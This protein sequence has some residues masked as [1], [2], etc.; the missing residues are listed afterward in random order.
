MVNAKKHKA[1]RQLTQEELL[2]DL[3]INLIDVLNSNPDGVIK[4]LTVN[5]NELNRIYNKMLA[6]EGSVLAS[7]ECRKIINYIFRTDYSLE[8]IKLNYN[9]I[10]L[11]ADVI[12]TVLN[13]CYE[14]LDIFQKIQEL[15]QANIHDSKY[16]SL[17]SV[18]AM[19][20]LNNPDKPLEYYSS[21]EY[22]N[23]INLNVTYKKD[24]IH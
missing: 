16:L 1:K 13:L 11:E 5:N 24:K 4:E 3:D 15:Q 10:K 2:Q 23:L 20:M 19:E 17:D 6:K 9:A 12:D 22:L 8:T 18:K 21:E 14:A 7:T